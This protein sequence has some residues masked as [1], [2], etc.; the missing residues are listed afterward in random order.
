MLKLVV[1]G[2]EVVLTEEHPFF[3][4]RQGWTPAHLLVPGD[5]ILG[6]ENDWVEVEAVENTGRYEIVYNMT[7]RDSHTFFVGKPEWDFALWVHNSGPCPLSGK[8]NAPKAIDSVLQDAYRNLWRPQDTRPGGTIG[9]LLREVESGGPLTHLQK[10][11]ERLT[12]LLN[13]VNDTANPLSAADR[14]G[15]ERVINDLKD[16]IRIAEGR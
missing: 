1:R 11:K 7:V 2:Q 6:L 15:A 4:F 3:T 5:L 12:S 9:E 14:A 16:A 10:A 13:R 8:V